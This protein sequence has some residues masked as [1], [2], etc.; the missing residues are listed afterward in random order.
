[1][2]KMTWRI[3]VCLLPILFNSLVPAQQ[4]RTLSEISYARARAALDAAIEAMGDVKSLQA[5]DDI[6]LEFSAKAVEIGQ[7][8][9]PDAPYYVTTAEGLR[10]IDFRGNR[11]YQE[12]KSHFLGE[13]PF[14][15]REVLTDN[16]GFTVE[17]TS[18]VVYP[19]S[20]AA[21]PQNARG[22]QRLFPQFILQNALNRASTLR[23]LGEE[24]YEGQ[25][26]QVITFADDGGLFA[27]YIDARTHL[28]TKVETL[29]DNRLFGTS[30]VEFIFTNY[31]SV[32]NLKLPLRVISKLAGRLTT[33]LTYTEV[34]VRT[35]PNDALFER[36]KGAEIGP[37]T[38]GQPAIN[39][40]KL[41]DDV[42]FV[43][44]PLAFRGNFCFNDIFAYSQ[45]FVIFRD[46]VLVVEAPISDGLSRAV[47][48]KIKEVA[49]GKPIKYVIPTHYHSDHMGGIRGY[50][51]EGATVVTTPGNKSFIEK[52]ASTPHPLNR[53]APSVQDY[54]ALIETFAEKRIFSDGEHRVEVFNIGPTPHVDEMVIVYLP[55]EKIV[56]ASDVAGIFAAPAKVHL[57]TANP[58]SIDFVEK[59]RRLG[60]EVETIA[61][62]HGWVGTMEKL[63]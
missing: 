44:T 58:A 57:S 2:I 14:Q 59:I 32:E 50:V 38:G 48:A 46:Y 8:A 21:V 61:S 29:A 11:S 9:S 56:F 37:E 1:M 16:A 42:Y 31:R 3:A 60:L 54:R 55:K 17:L 28:L 23:W 20:S 40:T 13:I 18:N 26:Q 36:P 30:A 43:T 52:W 22:V 33:D 19:V 39:V 47:I 6:S 24:E 53:D 49:P 15:L 5:L 10:V 62:G 34:K 25:K 63:R 51:A 7:S 41:A 35:H 12:F 45:L 27:L 4:S